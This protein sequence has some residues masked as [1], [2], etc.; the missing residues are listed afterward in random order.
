METFWRW[1]NDGNILEV[2]NNGNFLEVAQQYK[3]SGV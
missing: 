1:S 3:L 2:S